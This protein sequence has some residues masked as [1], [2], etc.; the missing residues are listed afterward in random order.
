[1]TY[2]RLNLCCLSPHLCFNQPPICSHPPAALHF[3]SE[4]CWIPEPNTEGFQ[5]AP[6]TH[7]HLLC[8]PA[9]S[10]SLGRPVSSSP[11]TLSC[12]LMAPCLHTG[13]MLGSQLETQ[14]LEPD[15]SKHFHFFPY[16]F[17]PYLV[18]LSK[19]LT[20]LSHHFFICKMGAI[21]STLHSCSEN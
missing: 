2:L 8:A 3:P 7:L 9:G 16:H 19:S 10:A 4:S 12:S 15:S 1:M 11:P 13:G 17:F 18:T 20:S 21:I 14:A 6:Y 5:P